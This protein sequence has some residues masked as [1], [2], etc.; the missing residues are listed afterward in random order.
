MTNLQLKDALAAMWGHEDSS[1]LPARDSLDIQQ[2]VNDALAEC[3]SPIEPFKK[4][5]QWTE[6]YHA[7]VLKAPAPATLTL[8]QGST[9]IAVAGLALEAKYAGSFVRI[10]ERLYRYAGKDLSGDDHLV[11]PWAEATQ[12]LPASVFYNSVLLPVQCVAVAEEPLILGVGRLCPLS[13]VAAEAALRHEFYSDFN[14]F[15]RQR[16]RSDDAHT[17]DPWFYH[18]DSAG[19]TPTFSIRRRFVVYPLPEAAFT[20]EMRINV[21]PARLSADDDV[22]ALPGDGEDYDMVGNVLL[23]LARDYLVLNSKGRRF[24]GDA[25][26]IAEAASR[27]RSR[28]KDLARPQRQTA[29]RVVPRRGW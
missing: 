27:A 18:I 23:P 1:L 16:F 9:T 11:Q 29:N 24:E 2:W 21:M 17:G 25:R 19:V 22:P 4:R 14:S 7:D 3:Y 28:L 8:T 5:G 26:E 13:G 15:A 20:F 12:S 6:R 10:G